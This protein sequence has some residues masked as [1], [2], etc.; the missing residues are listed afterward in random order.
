MALMVAKPDLAALRARVRS[1]LEQEIRVQTLLEDRDGDLMFTYG[2]ERFLL[3]FHP[4]DP[5]ALWIAERFGLAVI[6][7][8]PEDLN[9]VDDHIHRI[10]AEFHLATLWRTMMDGS[11][12]YRIRSAAPIRVGRIHALNVPFIEQYLLSTSQILRAFRRLYGRPSIPLE[13]VISWH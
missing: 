13:E 7:S 12:S 6:A 3:C 2:H 4:N 9:N 11:G 8:T 10:N 5:G 1:L